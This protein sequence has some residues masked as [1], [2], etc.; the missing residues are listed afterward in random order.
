MKQIIWLGSSFEDL[1]AFPKG[2]KQSA[3]YS[4]DKIQRGQD[5]A[6][7]KSMLSIGKVLRKLEF[8]GTMSIE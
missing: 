7:W 1:L 8:M 5:P 6:D 3:G 2:V 4:L